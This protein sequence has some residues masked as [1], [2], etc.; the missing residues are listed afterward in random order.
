MGLLATALT[1]LAMTPGCGGPA[2][3]ETPEPPS[4]FS[5]YYER[6]GGLKP[7][8]QRLVVRP[9][10][11]ATATIREGSDSRGTSFKVGV[12]R[13]RSL[14]AALERAD[15]ETIGTPGP[16][17]GVCADCF[18]YAIRYRGHEVTF[19]QAE[20]PKRLR[21]VVRQIEAMI[22]AHLPFH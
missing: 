1:C 7:M 19:N 10:R 17:P 13:I 16:N 3:V 2:A 4:A 5:I 6:G 14:Q 15:F 20:V 22:E 9:G 11:Q 12:R 8:P 18:F 21:P